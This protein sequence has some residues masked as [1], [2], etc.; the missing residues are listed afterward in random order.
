MKFPAPTEAFWSD[1]TVVRDLNDAPVTPGC[2][3]GR[4]GW[5][6]EEPEVRVAMPWMSE[7][8]PDHQFYLLLGDVPGAASWKD[9]RFALF[10]C[11]A[12]YQQMVAKW[13]SGPIWNRTGTF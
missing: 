5:R 9:H 1:P 3:G 8:D 6:T 13:H 4:K 11:R 10:C 2:H 12:W 7:R